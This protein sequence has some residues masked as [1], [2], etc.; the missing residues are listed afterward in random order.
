MDA[1]RYGCEQLP[2]GSPSAASLGAIRTF[3]TGELNDNHIEDLIWGLILVNQYGVKV[4]TRPSQFENDCLPPR[5]YALLKLL[6]LPRPLVIDRRNDGTNRVRLAGSNEAGGIR[7][8]PEPSILA[9]L[10]A[11]HL[12]DACAIATRRLRASGLAPLPHS[13]TGKTRDRDWGELDHMGG[14]AMD[15]ARL[16]AALL[17][18]IDDRAVNL[19]ARLITRGDDDQNDRAQAIAGPIS[20]GDMPS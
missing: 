15:T 17:I 9:R 20:E 13:R 12:G 16:A 11:G 18:P 10:R 1:E 8:R 2:V 3:I 14:A 4:S 6:F 19:L 7:I 5:A